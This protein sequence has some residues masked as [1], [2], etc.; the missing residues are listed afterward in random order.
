MMLRSPGVILWMKMVSG[1]KAVESSFEG[2]DRIFDEHFWRM[3]VSRS[4]KNA[5][6]NG[7]KAAILY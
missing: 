5:N 3:E 4:P 6:H 7:L 1:P 2:C